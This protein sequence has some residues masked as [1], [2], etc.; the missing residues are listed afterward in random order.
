MGLSCPLGSCLGLPAVVRK[1]SFPDSH[2]ISPYWPSLFGQDGWIQAER[3]LANI[4]PSWLYVWS[5]HCDFAVFLACSTGK[6]S[7]LPCFLC[8]RPQSKPYID[9][10]F[11]QKILLTKAVQH[12][13]DLSMVCRRLGPYQLIDK[14]VMYQRVCKNRSRI[15][16]WC[17]EPGRRE[18]FCSI[19]FKIW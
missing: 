1:K 4:Q 6:K 19:A 13:P 14:I 11:W 18:I 16:M 10:L 17:C 7:T 8:C 12:C 9:E 15:A 3:N 2:I 5:V